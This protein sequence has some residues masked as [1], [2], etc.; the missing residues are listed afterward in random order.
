[1]T[2]IQVSR[3]FRVTLVTIVVT[4]MTIIM[5]FVTLWPFISPAAYFTTHYSTMQC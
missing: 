4:I 5:T 1:M 3:E 2:L